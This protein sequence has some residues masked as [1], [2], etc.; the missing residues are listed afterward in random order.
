M[1][2]VDDDQTVRVS[3]GGLNS[4]TGSSRACRIERAPVI[5]SHIARTL[6]TVVGGQVLLFSCVAR[7]IIHKA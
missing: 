4:A 1:C 6:S 7:Q 3:L 5:D 2:E